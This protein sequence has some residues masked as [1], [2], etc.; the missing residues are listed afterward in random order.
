MTTSNE[1]N[2]NS[3]SINQLNTLP[4]NTPEVTGNPYVGPQTFTSA[5]RHLF[6]GRE[7]E[8]RDLL[9]L[10]IAN[11]VV[12]F[13]AQSGA[14]KSSLVNTRLIP[15][16]EERSFEVLPVGRVGGGDPAD[17]LAP[18]NIYVHNLMTYLDGRPERQANFANQP[19]TELLQGMMWDGRD[20]RYV[21]EEGGD[22]D[23]P[24]EGDEYELHPRVLIIDQFEE[25][26]TT[27][28]EA[29][30]RRVDFFQ[31]L[32]TAL[33]DDPFLWLV[34][35]MRED[36][37]GGLTPFSHLLPGG[38]RTR[39]HM[40]RMDIEAALDAIRKPAELGGRPFGPGVAEQ[41]VDNLRQIR[42]AGQPKTQSGQYLEPVQL[43][44]VCYQLWEDLQS[45]NRTGEITHADLQESGDVDSALTQFYEEIL[46]Q[47][48]QQPN[49][50]TSERALREWFSTQMITESGT[51]STAYRNEELGQ[52]ANL[53]NPVVDELT[54]RFL[55]RTEL[56]AG[57]AWTELVHDRFVEPIQRANTGWLTQNPNPVTQAYQRWMANGSIEKQL[58]EGFALSELETFAQTNPKDVSADERTFLTRSRN[59]VRIRTRTRIQTISIAAAVM[60]ALIAL[61]VYA[62]IQT[63]DASNARD[64]AETR[65]AEAEEA[66]TTAE[67]QATVAADARTTAEGQATVAADA[68]STAEAEAERAED[69]AVR[70]DAQANRALGLLLR[71]N[72]QRIVNDDSFLANYSSDRDIS[73]ILARDRLLIDPTVDSDQALRAAV[74]NARWRRTF[75]APNRRHQG[76]VYSTV[77]SPDGQTIA[78]GGADGTIRLWRSSDLTP[79]KLIFGHTSTVLSVGFSP[80]GARIVSGSSDTTVR[81]W[82]AE[83]GEELATLDGHTSTVWSVGFSPDGAHIVS[84][85]EDNTVRLWDAE[86]GEELATLDGH[87]STVWSV[88]FSPDGA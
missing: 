24:G 46:A 45:N 8:A 11:R 85:S 66:R 34:L 4:G 77:F 75:P 18:Q 5:Q 48:L 81:L 40:E 26:L 84:G 88:G 10:V 28:P 33:E 82:D 21:E 29:W 50:E 31:Q 54:R 70:A 51:R 16:L 22:G 47:V 76:I 55:L 72:Q 41:L 59:Q 49:I 2:I 87:T 43:Q 65:E 37:V 52:T 3:P 56:R 15:G 57:G 80:D 12:L 68:R 1:A 67:Y 19:L 69:E 36:Y 78:S 74:A 62:L 23:E 61:T 83:S 79:L 35:V 58:P 60:V 73:L 53:P 7:R 17:G 38:L 44:V 25:I 20:W 14:G 13:F 39:Y 27:H 6:F 86:S 42:V 9:S 71:V 32:R 64:T 30:G 63:N